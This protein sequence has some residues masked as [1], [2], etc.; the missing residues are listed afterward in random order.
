MSVV[1]VGLGSSETVAHDRSAQL[2]I[3]LV[4]FERTD[5]LIFVLARPRTTSCRVPENLKV[6]DTVVFILFRV[7][8]Q[9]LQVIRIDSNPGERV[10]AEVA[11]DR[12]KVEGRLTDVL[13]A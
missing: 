13:T 12:V 3:F 4:A 2:I 9:C 10:V 1:A 6:S 8:A 7:I 5:L 11:V